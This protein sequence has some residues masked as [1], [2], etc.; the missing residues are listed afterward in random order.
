MNEPLHYL[1]SLTGSGDSNKGLTEV[2]SDFFPAIILTYDLKKKELLSANNK[3]E[4]YLGFSNQEFENLKYSL[5]GIALEEDRHI[6]TAAVD[7]FHS[8]PVGSAVDFTAR[9][10]HKNGEL[11][12]LKCC[13]TKF[14]PD[15][16][17]IIGQNVSEQLKL[18]EEVRATRQLFDETEKLLSFGTWSWS[19]AANQLEWTDGMYEILGYRR[20]EVLQLSN[21]FYLKHVVP[22]HVDHVQSVVKAATM[23]GQDFEMEY[24]I[25]TK[26][27]LEKFVY[28]KA[29][30]LL[31]KDGNLTKIVGIT[32]DVTAKK[33]FEQ[34][35]DRIIRELNRSNKELEEFAYVASH[36]LH[37]PLRKILTFAERIKGRFM[38]SIGDDGKIYL[39]RIWSSADSMRKLIDNLLEFSK[40][41]RGSRTFVECDLNELLKEVVSDQELRIEETSTVLQIKELP[42]VSGIPSQLRQLFNNLIS[43]ALKF[44]KKDVPPA[45]TISSRK[46][47]H[48][49]KA[50][51]LLPFNE[52]YFQINIEDNGIGFEAIYSEKIFE[53]F[54]RLHG[55]VEYNGS[56]IGLAICK[57]IVDNHD[58]LI[59]ATSELGIGSTF[60]VILPE[61][62]FR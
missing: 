44:R 13:C 59:Y 46:L 53:I 18:E 2:C 50:D 37:E 5:P 33:K 51:Q 29:K 40:I 26:T 61:K 12:W 41:S 6:V 32:S 11:R 1:A 54:Q 62:Q 4:E 39:D 22:E 43:N 30:S 16:V 52:S 19:V 14:L 34:E 38:S 60:S 7:K 8:L 9:F 23:S 27:G 24:V 49:E 10:V 28:T 45:I 35:R 25:R 58:G 36:D 47:T 20:S 57:K 17:M 55:K 21:E 3:L 15:A 48:K 56:G 42:V 31:D